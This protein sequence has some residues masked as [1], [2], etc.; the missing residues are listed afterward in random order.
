MQQD[1]EKAGER[2]F[3]EAVADQR[4][5]AQPLF[6]ELRSQASGMYSGVSDKDALRT[7]IESDFKYHAPKPGQAEIYTGV[8]DKA[9]DLA[10][11]LVDAV[12]NGRELSTALTLLEQVVMVANAGI[13]RHGT[14][15]DARMFSAASAD[16]PP[17]QSGG[18]DLDVG[19]EIGLG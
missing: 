4:S 11:H 7:R 3:Q 13:A 8:R 18:V 5:D 16:P 1:T 15:E 2:E 17:P 10:L 6:S 9:K 19:V 12:P 14:T